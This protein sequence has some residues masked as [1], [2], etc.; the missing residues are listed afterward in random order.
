MKKTQKLK[1]LKASL[2]ALIDSDP[3]DLQGFQSVFSDFM[4]K[5]GFS[6]VPLVPTTPSDPSSD[7]PKSFDAIQKELNDLGVSD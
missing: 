1:A 2:N 7:V 3:T 5:N 6:S 4:V